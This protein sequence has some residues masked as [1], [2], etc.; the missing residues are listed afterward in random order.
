MNFFDQEDG[1][2]VDF[3]FFSFG[4][5]GSAQA[6]NLRDSGIP[7]S[8]ILIANRRDSYADVARDKGFTVEHDFGKVALLTHHLAHLLTRST[9]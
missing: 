2:K 6:Q 5:Q 4:N 9:Y 7:N 1:L 8:A 3:Y